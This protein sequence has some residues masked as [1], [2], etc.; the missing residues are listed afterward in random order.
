MLIVT[1]NWSEGVRVL[2]VWGGRASVTRK[3]RVVQQN[4]DIEKEVT[5][6]T[7]SRAG[8]NN[9]ISR[10]E[11]VRRNGR[12]WATTNRDVR[13]KLRVWYFTL[14]TKSSQY[15]FLFKATKPFHSSQ[16]NI[17]LKMAEE[18]KSA[19]EKKKSQLRF[20]VG[21]GGVLGG[22]VLLGGGLAAAGLMAAFAIIKNRNSGGDDQKNKEDSS[23]A[24]TTASEKVHDGTQGLSSVLQNPTTAVHQNYWLA[25]QLKF[26]NLSD[27]YYIWFSTFLMWLFCSCANHV[28]PTIGVIESPMDS[29]ELVSAHNL[30]LVIV[31]NIFVDRKNCSIIIIND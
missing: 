8:E 24:A 15:S 21:S 30:A 1:I 20:N 26:S 25:S 4:K 2:L 9:R 27:C 22:A 23:A 3:T 19:R 13:F 5:E 31:R 16:T 10:S 11:R 28:T 12:Y 17:K 14:L 29:R 7:W 18:D 6:Q